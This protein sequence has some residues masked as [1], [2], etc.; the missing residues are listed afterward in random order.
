[1]RSPSADTSVSSPIAVARH[2]VPVRRVASVSRAG[3]IERLTLSERPLVVITAPAGY[4]KTTLLVELAV[5]DPRSVV[6]LSLDHADDD[7]VQLALDLAAALAAGGLAEET[8]ADEIR[9]PVHGSAASAL[10][11]LGQALLCAAAPFVLI[12]DDVHLVSD[13]DGRRLLDG[14]VDHLPAGSQLV[15]GGR[16]E[17]PF[18]SRRRVSAEVIEF[19]TADL[20]LTADGVRSVFESEGVSITPEQACE[21]VERTEGWAAGVYLSVLVSGRAGGDTVNGTR[22][23]TGSS[24]QL[25]DYLFHHVL[26][27]VDAEVQ[28]FLLDVALLDDMH[29]ALCDDITSRDDSVELLRNLEASNLFASAMGEERDWY[30]LHSL[31][32]EFLLCER[33]RRRRSTQTAEALGR[34]ATWCEANGQTDQAVEYL[35]RAQDIERLGPMLT[36]VMQ[37]AYDE[38]RSVTVDRWLRE[39]GE[40]VIDQH[41]P[42]AVLAGWMAALN[43]PPA[44]AMELASRVNRLEF[45][46]GTE[47]GWLSFDAARSAF[48]ALICADGVAVMNE[49]A[50]HAV[51]GAPPWSPWR[52]T[53]LWLL[54]LARELAGVRGEASRLYDDAIAADLDAGR[55]PLLAPVVYG[56]LVAIDEGEWEIAA[57]RVEIAVQRAE[58]ILPA[59]YLAGGMAHAAAARVAMHRHEHRG[60]AEHLDVAM[61]SRRLGTYAVPHAAIRI[62]TDM[63]TVFAALGDQD[64]AVSLLGET[65]SIV[66]KRPDLGSLHDEIARVR[67]LLTPDL[68]GTTALTPGELRVLAL[69]PT[70]LNFAEIGKQLFISRHTVHTHARSIYRK[71][72]VTSRGDAVGRA[73]DLG[74]A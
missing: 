22:V 25:A 58:V 44:A 30:R 32:R 23:V 7:P 17:L 15:L 37:P 52:S 46:G 11:L 20:V 60:A 4:G 41:P 66:A 54:G 19:T 6:W 71:F 56:T 35:L 45:D 49:D 64:S 27:G 24:P 74:L 62:R 70:H 68:A 40:A 50:E 18:V 38:G 57:E 9:G 12:L 3:L 2:R 36:S 28:E 69:L 65:D 47:D 33:S 1:M 48:R 10:V 5:G 59:D 67:R 42:L 73:T 21:V 26:D 14:L 34:A 29:P 43:G 61:A 63:A 53:A 13:P 51:E 55:A 39:A 16:A 72:G 8:L 31:F